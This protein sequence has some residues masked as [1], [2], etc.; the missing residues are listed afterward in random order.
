MK[1]MRLKRIL[2]FE[3]LYSKKIQLC[4]CDGESVK[5]KEEIEEIKNNTAWD[6]RVERQ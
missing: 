1:V 5:Y 2:S 6:C 3:R 4:V